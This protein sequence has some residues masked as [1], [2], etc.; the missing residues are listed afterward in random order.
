TKD[1]SMHGIGAFLFEIA[2]FTVERNLQLEVQITIVICVRRTCED[3]LELFAL[4]HSEGILEV[5]DS[6]LPMRILTVRSGGESGLFVAFG[7]LD[8]EVSNER[9]YVVVAVHAEN[10]L[11]SPG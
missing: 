10:K 8:S 4:F 2:N 11:R 5:E 7:E 1:D 3:S 6:L 9:L